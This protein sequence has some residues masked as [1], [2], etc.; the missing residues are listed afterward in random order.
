MPDLTPDEV[1]SALGPAPTPLHDALWAGDRAT[2][3]ALVAAGAD[4]NA[5]DTRP[6]VGHGATPLHLVA[7]AN[8]PTLVHALVA[9]GAR[10]DARSLAGQTPLWWA[11]NAGRV[12]AARELLAAGADPNVRC[13][14]GYGPL[15]RVYRSEPALVELVRSHGG[16]V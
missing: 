3:L 4:P 7:D 1:A 5:A 2:A 13:H 8:D 9:A 11:C 10:E 16:V 6:V 12:A 15:G 14:E